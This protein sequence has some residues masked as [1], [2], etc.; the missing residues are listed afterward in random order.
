[1]RAAA[2]AALGMALVA[3]VDPGCANAPFKVYFNEGGPP[4]KN[5]DT[6]MYLIVN[7]T[8]TQTGV[9]CSSSPNCTPW[10]P[11]FPFI[12][13]DGNAVNGGVPQAGNLTA[14]LAYLR[15][16]IGGWIP[17]PEWDGNAIFDF[18][19]W[20]PLWEENTTPGASWHGLAYQNLSIALMSAAHP[21]WN[22]SEVVTAAAAAFEAAGL[23]FFVET[24][25]LCAEL[26][27]RARWAFYG[28]PDTPFWP[29]VGGP[30]DSEPQCGYMHPVA[31]PAQRARNDRLAPL[32]AVSGA[33]LPSGYFPYNNSA[34]VNMTRDYFL[35]S[36]AESQRIVRTWA[37]PG[38]PVLPFL[39]NVYADTDGLGADAVFLTPADMASALNVGAAL[40]VEGVVLWGAPAFFNQTQRFE[41]YLSTT[42]GPLSAAAVETACACGAARCS[43]HGACAGATACRCESG[44]TGQ[45]CNQTQ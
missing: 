29:C 14:H 22:S 9:D 8:M 28:F 18:E 2:L 44:W 43:G 40:G 7:G 23:S 6:S 32:W 31:G 25:R 24:L 42:L 17:D 1:M 27:P 11:P 30:G 4:F 19:A 45:S 37:R 41:E 13:G 33:M 39:W 38:T 21:S 12:D 35:G 3:A 20:T 5:M 34:Y 15:E 16:H 10:N 26:R 36:A